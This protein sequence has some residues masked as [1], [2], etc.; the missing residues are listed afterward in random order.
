MSDAGSNYVRLNELQKKKEETA[1]KLDEKMER[2]SYLE[3][4]AERIRDQDS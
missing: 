4:L 3:E 1:R 2:W